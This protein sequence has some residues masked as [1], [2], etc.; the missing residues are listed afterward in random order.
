LYPD[1]LVI[2]D[3]TGGMATNDALR[4]IVDTARPRW[5]FVRSF[6]MIFGPDLR[7]AIVAA[8]LTTLARL[9]GRQWLGAMWVSH[10]LQR[11]TLMLLTDERAMMR[12]REARR[13]YE[14]RRK[15]LVEA[16]AAHAIHSSSRSGFH[17]WIPVRQEAATI[18]ALQ[19]VGWAVAAGEPFRLQT[20]P[21]I[22]ITAS[23]LNAA[24]A[25]RFARHLA[26]ILWR[27]A[28]RT[29]TGRARPVP[30][31]ASPTHSS[32]AIGRAGS[33]VYA[34]W[35][36]LA[37]RTE[38]SADLAHEGCCAIRISTNPNM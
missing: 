31:R 3:D 35:S 36:F 10:I 30:D 5:A 6:S 33:A 29:T 32:Y 14:V 37:V 23:R 22:R 26:E 16:L 12:V 19:A 24:D 38:T 28:T 4:S 20:P 27:I 17:V 25:T 11:L 7:T 15:R 1:V 18:A 2:E 21:G 8:D 34:S 13:A 9:E